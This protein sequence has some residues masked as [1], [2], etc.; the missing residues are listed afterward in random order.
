[1]IDL[2]GEDT[3][4]WQESNPTWFGFSWINVADNIRIITVARL[5][6]GRVLEN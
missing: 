3:A 6:R 2:G 4:G 5:Q 1:M